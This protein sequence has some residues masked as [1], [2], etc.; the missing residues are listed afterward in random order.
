M[1]IEKNKLAHLACL[2]ELQDQL[3]CQKIQ[4][5]FLGK[6]EKKLQKF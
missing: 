2:Y 3:L 1:F 5:L 6:S 4:I